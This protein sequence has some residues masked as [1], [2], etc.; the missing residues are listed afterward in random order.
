MFI[1]NTIVTFI[2]RKNAGASSIFFVKQMSGVDRCSLDTETEMKDPIQK[3]GNQRI[4]IWRGGLK[5][6]SDVHVKCDLSILMMIY[7]LL[8][9]DLRGV[10]LDHTEVHAASY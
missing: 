3:V 10:T 1:F 4:G 2:C 8:Q 6:I 9:V 5:L 7:F